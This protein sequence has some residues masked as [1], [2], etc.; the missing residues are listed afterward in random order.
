MWVMAS[1]VLRC[2]GAARRTR[3]AHGLTGPAAKL[4]YC[5]KTDCLRPASKATTMVA[6]H[7]GAKPLGIWEGCNWSNLIAEMVP[8]LEI[9]PYS[10]R[11]AGRMCNW[12]SNKTSCH[13]YVKSLGCVTQQS[14]VQVNLVVWSRAGTDASSL[15]AVAVISL[16][17]RVMHAV[18]LTRSIP[19]DAAHI[20]IGMHS[21][22]RH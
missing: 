19:S 8:G 4:L 12:F 15:A 5:G 2:S 11:G 1:V 9:L 18:A 21:G 20:I 17:H 22:C 13:A 14:N 7:Y 3:R 6:A 16:L 10:D